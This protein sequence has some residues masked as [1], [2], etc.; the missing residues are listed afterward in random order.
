MA[1]V[2][3]EDLYRC[4]RQ[5]GVQPR[6]EVFTRTLRD[7]GTRIIEA[8]IRIRQRL[9]APPVSAIEKP[10]D[11]TRWRGR[12]AGVRQATGIMDT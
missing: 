7:T 1:R 3:I 12:L 2:T 10:G 5:I 11:Y 8:F 6:S 4:A 9:H